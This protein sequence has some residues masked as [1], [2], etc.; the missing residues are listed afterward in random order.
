MRSVLVYGQNGEKKS[1][2]DIIIQKA[3]A[4]GDAVT[5]LNNA[6][7]SVEDNDKVMLIRKLLASESGNFIEVFK[8]YMNYGTQIAG[9][10]RDPNNDY[11]WEIRSIS[12][13]GI[14]KSKKQ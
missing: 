14:A 12:A 11:T 7:D 5:N 13:M 9:Y 3:G 8:K 10:P 1:Y 6:I 4:S 2:L